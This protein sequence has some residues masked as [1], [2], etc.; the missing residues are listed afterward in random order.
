MSCIQSATAIINPM[1]VQIIRLFIL[2]FTAGQKVSATLI[3][4]TA[5]IVTLLMVEW[6][7]P[8]VD[9][10]KDPEDGDAHTETLDNG[11]RIKSWKLY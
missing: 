7:R 4:A 3:V 11:A 5:W 6:T 8:A 10:R 9:R 2:L 1:R